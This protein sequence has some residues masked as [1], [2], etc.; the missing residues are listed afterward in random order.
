VA[1]A[2][3]DWVVR[4]LRASDSRFEGWLQRADELRLQILVTVVE[5]QPSGPPRLTEHGYRVDA[6]YVYPASAIKT[7]LAVAALRTLRRLSEK[8]GAAVDG[9]T[10]IM[11]CR[12]DRGGC[13]PPPA[14]AKGRSEAEDAEHER[15]WVGQEIRKL[16][17]YSDNDS[18]D[19]LY[20]IVGH[21]ELNVEMAALGFRTVRFHHRMNAP[22]SRSR[23]L[24][25][26]T[27]LPRGGRAID[28]PRRISDFDPAP[29]PASR[30]DVGTAH[31]GERG[32]VEAPMSFAAKNYASLRDMQRLNLSLLLPGHPGALDLGLDDAARKLLIEPMTGRLRPLRNA[33]RHKPLLPGVLEVLPEQ[34]VRYVG[35]SGRAYGFH[36]EN[37]YV[38]DLESKR[39]MLVTVSVYANP[40]GVLNDDNYDYDDTTKP[41][42]SALGKALATGVFGG[43]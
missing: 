43:G 2:P 27:L 6:E 11:R 17:S 36:L 4:S 35:K 15:L 42:L 13:K 3:D 12:E 18:Y 31:L 39:G 29:T 5:P 28:I 21:R 24:R 30:L 37:A 19:R 40:N 38:Q 8:A 41:L 22:A 10:R 32:R 20:D 23:I 25:R 1:K 9:S 16:L 14:D 34:R 26:V 33:E 7:F